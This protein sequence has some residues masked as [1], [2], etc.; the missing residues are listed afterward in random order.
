MAQQ[1]EIPST[2]G[3]DAAHQEPVP[4]QTHDRNC[5]L[6]R[7]HHEGTG[8]LTGTVVPQGTRAGV[9]CS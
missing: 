3:E 6:C 9:V 5:D 8:F 4:E 1:V 2:A 7:G